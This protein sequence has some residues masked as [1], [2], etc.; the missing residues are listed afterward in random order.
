L[1][2]NQTECVFTRVRTRRGYYAQTRGTG[3][4]GTS[5]RKIPG[6]SHVPGHNPRAHDPRLRTASPSSLSCRGR[7]SS[8]KPSGSC[9]Q[10]LR[11]E[12]Q[13]TQ[14]RGFGGVTAGGSARVK[15][16]SVWFPKQLAS[17]GES[18]CPLGDGRDGPLPPSARAAAVR[19]RGP[20]KSLA[21]CGAQALA[22][23]WGATSA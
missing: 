13:R 2:R 8:G 22:R 3:Y 10:L 21:L 7:A 16:H 15:H 11:G 18:R 6:G 5:P 12:V 20:K 1:L 17:S 19:I 23:I 14:S 9:T 4:A